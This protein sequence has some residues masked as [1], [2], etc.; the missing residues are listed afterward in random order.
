MIVIGITGT[1]GAGKGT[2]VD[3]LVKHHHFLHL[4]VRQFLGRKLTRQ[5]KEINRQSLIDT[6]NQLRCLHGADYIALSLY[7]QAQKTASNCVIESLRTPAEAQTLKSIGNF[8]LLSV[9]ANPSLRY[10]RILTRG[11]NT[12]HVSFDQFMATQFQEMSSADPTKQNLA[13]CIALADYHLTNNGTVEDLY[14]QVK[15]IIDQILANHR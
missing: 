1:T 10:Q 6:A 5:G 3:Y 15:I 14:R 13:G 2:V 9:D 7:Q 8:C 11:S 12:D 4:S